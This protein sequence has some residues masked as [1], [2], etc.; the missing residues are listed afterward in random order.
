[1]CGTALRPGQLAEVKRLVI[2]LGGATYDGR[3]TMATTHLLVEGPVNQG[4]K[5]PTAVSGA[6]GSIILVDSKWVFAS[7]A[8]GAWLPESDFAV[9]PL[10]GLVV[11]ST[12]LN[13]TARL[14]AQEAVEKGGGTFQDL[15]RETTHLLALEARGDEYGR[16]VQYGKRE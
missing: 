2:Q 1:L 6:A 10:R 16:A 8:E 7:A 13:E 11:A 15:S 14:A 5:Y 4:E 3:L 12:G 9:P